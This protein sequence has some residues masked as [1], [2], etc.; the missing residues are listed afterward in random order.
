MEFLKR[1][2]YII[3]LTVLLMPSVIKLTH[4][5]CD[6]AS[7]AHHCD[8]DHHQKKEIST[9]KKELSFHKLEIDCDICS[10]HLH[11]FASTEIQH[12]LL[13]FSEKIDTF[14]NFYRSFSLDLNLLFQLRAPP[15]LV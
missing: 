12:I 2:L 11:N 7:L 5:C 4:H 13:V 15:S 8:D 1:Y 6:V 10:F 9:S 14:A 3:V